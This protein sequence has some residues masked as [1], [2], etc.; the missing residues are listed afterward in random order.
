MELDGLDKTRLPQHVAIIMDGNGRWA[1]GRGKHRIEGHR[2]GKTSVRVIVEMSRKVGIRFLSLYAFSTENWYRPDDEVGA[3]MMLLEHYLAAE[4]A[5]M[6]RYGIRLLA[7][8]DRSRLPASVRGALER[9]IDMTRDN[10]RMTVV[11]ALS[12][13]GRDDILRMVRSLAREVKAEKLD[14]ENIGE[15]N[16]A[17]HLDT[18]GIPDPDLL[19][20]TSG[21]MR[22]SNFYL[23]QIA[24]SE[25]YVTSCLWPDFRE[26][27]YLQALLE[28]QRRRRRF[29]RTDEQLGEN[30]KSSL[31]AGGRQP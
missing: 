14:P 1:T 26:K 19:I 11:L 17:T 25:M 7:V 15:A 3:L 21:E 22:I 18:A 2:R 28:Y 16:I 4:Q 5:K 23:W 20:R 29:G 12:Y 6:M 8:G 31:D 27:E 30:H 13:S 9:V 24:Y 10:Q